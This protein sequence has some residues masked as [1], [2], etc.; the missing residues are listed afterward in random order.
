MK[1]PS[2][3]RRPDRDDAQ[4]RLRGRQQ[5]EEWCATGVRPR[6]G[7][8][9]LVSVSVCSSMGAR[10]M[11]ARPH[12]GPLVCSSTMRVGCSS[13]VRANSQTDGARF[14]LIEADRVETYSSLYSYPST[15]S[16]RYAPRPS[17]T[18]QE[19]KYLSYYPTRMIEHVRVGCPWAVRVYPEEDFPRLCQSAPLDTASWCLR[20]LLQRASTPRQCSLSSR[21]RQCSLS[22]GVDSA[23]CSSSALRSLDSLVCRWE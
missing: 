12:E 22:R 18:L 9:P 16:A 10:P 19:E 17:L 6:M 15:D 7:Q 4:A 20:L 8:A 14:P 5:G 23:V 11:R 1:Q 21:V 3:T 2:F 13:T